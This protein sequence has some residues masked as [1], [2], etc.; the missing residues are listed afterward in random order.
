MAIILFAII[1]AQINVGAWYWIFY[2][3]FCIMQVWKSVKETIE[4][5]F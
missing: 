1:G 3:L 4:E 2:G 5:K